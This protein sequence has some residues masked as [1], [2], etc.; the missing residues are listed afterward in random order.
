MRRA[1]AYLQIPAEYCRSFGGLRW[2]QYG[3][4][5][6]FLEGRAAGRT[7][8]FSR[9]LALFVEGLLASHSP[10]PDFGFVLHLLYL[11]GLG[12]RAGESAESR[13]LDRVAA[14]FRDEGCPLR[15]AG[16]L[17]GLLCRGAPRGVDPPDPREINDLLSR[18]SW[19]P[20]MVMSHPSLGVIEPS[21]HPSLEPAEFEL[22]VRKA[23]AELSSSEI[24]HWLKFGRS[25][26][27]HSGA[28]DHFALVP[29]GSTVL[30]DLDS[31]PRLAGISR[32]VT[33][34]EGA[35]SL[36]PRRLAWTERQDGGYA[37]VTNRGTPEQILPIQF[38]LESEEFLR[39]FAERELLF[40]QREQ[41]HQAVTDELVLLLD[42]G[43]RTWG[44]PRLALSAAALA[45]ARQARR[46]RIAITLATTAADQAPIDPAQCDTVE[47]SGILEQSDLSANPGRALGSLLESPAGR[48]RDLVLLTHPRNLEE[49]EVAAAVQAADLSR[50]STFPTR[51]FS[52]SVDAAGQVAL[53]ELR[54]GLPVILGRS[55]VDL[56]GRDDSRL[57]SGPRFSSA[58][59][60]GI[61]KGPVEA[62][63]FPFRCGALD[64]LCKLMDGSRRQFAFDQSGDRILA[65]GRNGLLYLWRIDGTD[66]EILPRPM[67]DGEVRKSV[68]SVIGVAG[69]FVL[70]ADSQGFPTL[71]HYD[72]S[73]RTCV[74]HT[75]ERLGT[76]ITWNYHDDL[77]TISARPRHERLSVAID[78]SSTGRTA[79]R[80][81]RAMRAGARADGAFVADSRGGITVDAGEWPWAEQSVSIDHETGELVYR[82]GPRGRKS[83]LPL[84]DGEPALKRKR[85]TRHAQGGDILAVQ[86]VGAD[87]RQV[88]YFISISRAVCLGFVTLGEPGSRAAFELSRQGDRYAVVRG[89]HRLEVRDVPGSG[90]PVFVAP[91]EVAGDILVYLGRSRL[92]VQSPKSA[93]GGDCLDWIIRW[94]G[95]RF[96]AINGQVSERWTDRG[97]TFAASQTLSRDVFAAF[98]FDYDLRRFSRYVQFPSL[99]SG[100]FNSN[101]PFVL[102]DRYG[103]LAM[104][105]RRSGLVCLIYIGRDG[106]AAWMP[107]GT[108][109]GPRRLIGGEPTPGA[110]ERI[111]R[112]ITEAGFPGDPS[113]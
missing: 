73:S 56:E 11:I 97:D 71:I 37:D 99:G 110:P 26:S 48:R 57:V 77:H 83:V 66:S 42:Q 96:S 44:E 109:L 67:V 75:I 49:P 104:M 106:V 39:R 113:S 8:A 76:G 92:I 90:P 25:P 108:C 27:N 33:R 79:S 52:V 112:A 72:L 65:V 46:R 78:L 24:E 47:L 17:A 61:W 19:L 15:N 34:L 88:L 86:V 6:E 31:R 28:W 23:A 74:I 32:L 101:W 38:A 3:E 68:Q 85:I 51:V 55:R 36:P 111:A 4:A 45:L 7:F 50:P 18:G 9:E 63:P 35:L 40:Y 12:D 102:V 89:D 14:T 103:H 80:T 20:Q 5:V 95:G 105:G 41:P 93:K 13:C 21:S 62:I 69:G 2:A 1:A 22:F 64:Y 10:L 70:I 84:S 87:A 58:G 81:S 30:A 91:V 54:N 98:G 53:A 82:D 43:V 29:E 107:D 16:A 94:D 100:T 59:V 60:R